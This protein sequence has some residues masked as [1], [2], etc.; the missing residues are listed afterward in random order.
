MK[1]LLVDDD[2]ELMDMVTHALR[3][4]GH[5]VMTTSS[6][7]EAMEAVGRMAP[8]LVILDVR[9]PG[10]DGLTLCKMIREVSEVPIFMISGATTEEDI[11]NGLRAGADDYIFKP[12]SITQLALRIDAIGRRL[13]LA[14]ANDYEGALRVADLVIN[15]EYCSVKRGGRDIRL[16]RMEFRIL[17]CLA[18]N[19]G[20]VVVTD[21]LAD[22]AWQGDE[23]GDPALLKTHISRI[24]RKIGLNDGSGGSIE[25]LPGLGYSLTLS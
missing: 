7:D 23:E 25:A 1:I 5:T 4:R 3:K 2:V 13:R 20:R 24:R 12:F 21:K 18:A 6:A 14:A 17:Y 10:T 15:P 11:I 19:A 9:M 16:T 8:S 22:F